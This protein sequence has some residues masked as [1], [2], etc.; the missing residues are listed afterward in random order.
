MSFCS[1]GYFHISHCQSNSLISKSLSCG[2]KT[3]RGAKVRL[4]IVGVTLQLPFSS[5][6]SPLRGTSTV[7]LGSCCQ[8]IS[9]ESPSPPLLHGSGAKCR[10]QVWETISPLEEWI[11]LHSALGDN[12]THYAYLAT[13]VYLSRYQVHDGHRVQ[14]SVLR[15]CSGWRGNLPIGG[16]YRCLFP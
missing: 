9:S 4:T 6:C 1:F 13:E 14:W 3:L 10:L 8:E 7:T 2:K 5:F 11:V 15:P 12:H 16:S